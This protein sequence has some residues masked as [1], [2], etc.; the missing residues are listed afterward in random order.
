[1]ERRSGTGRGAGGFTLLELLVV[2]GIIAIIAGLAAPYYRGAKRK[3][4]EAVLREDLWIL[5]DV[6][7][8]HYA[9]KGKYPADLQVLVT[10]GYIRAIPADPMTGSSG[11]WE[12]VQVTQV[13]EGGLD[14]TEV[15]EGGIYDVHSGSPDQ[16]LDGTFY[17]DW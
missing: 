9:D 2:V 16:A 12:T 13:D 10:E 7:D 8:Q 1:M 4:E 15:E 17:R 3:A 11:T 6:I 5:R 14:E